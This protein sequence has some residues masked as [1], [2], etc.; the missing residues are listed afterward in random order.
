MT[1]AA[2]TLKAICL[3]DF[4]ATS[5]RTTS[6]TTMSRTPPMGFLGAVILFIVTASTAVGGERVRKPTLMRTG[7]GATCPLAVSNIGC[8]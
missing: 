5:L 8:K 3:A 1:V 2:P 6:P 7:K 4:L